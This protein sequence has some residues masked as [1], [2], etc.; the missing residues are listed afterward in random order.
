[1][2]KRFAIS[3]LVTVCAIV[4]IIVLLRN[5]G[6]TMPTGAS[7]QANVSIVDGKQVIQIDAKGGYTPRTTIAKANTPTVLNLK[8]NGTFDCSSSISIPSLGY[9]TNLPPSGTTSVEIPPQ[10]AGTTINGV[11]TMG[12]YHFAVNFN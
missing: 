2:K 6:T 3:I 11:C 7:V 9:S 4:G 5:G 1:M 12:M 10:L 8:T